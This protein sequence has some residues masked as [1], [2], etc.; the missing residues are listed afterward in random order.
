M[1]Y[2]ITV[3]V[4]RVHGYQLWTV[5]AKNEKE[6]LKLHEDGE[7]EFLDESV[8]VTETGDAT[9]EEDV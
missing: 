1:K 8:E 5:E 3:P 4:L 2:L 7:S 6:A 9:I